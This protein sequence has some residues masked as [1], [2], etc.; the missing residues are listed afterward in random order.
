MTVAG[1]LRYD[2]RVYVLQHVYAWQPPLQNEELWI[3][4]TDQPLPAAAAEDPLLAE[5]L[6]R[7]NRFGGVK[8]IVNPAR[9]R[10]DDIRGVVYAPHTDGY[11]IDQFN[12]GPSWQA[13][14]IADRRVAGRLRTEWMSWALQA[15][16]TA[17]V[18]GSSGTVRTVTGV[19]AQHSPQAEVFIAFE[20][21]LLDSGIEV[22][23][24][25]L[26][27]A[28]LADMRARL[29]R[30]GEAAFREFQ[31]RQRVSTAQ[32][33]ARRQQIERVDSDGD[34][35][36]LNARSGPDSVHTAVLVRIA[37]EWRIAEW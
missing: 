12:F 16:F 23:G 21:A 5:Q 25:Y 1:S 32:G 29:D 27:P 7:E 9:P 11:S 17:P 31:I 2:D 28:K 34:H 6:A 20:Q 3:Y 8:L 37:D 19:A 4:L 24:L 15:D 18:L 22:A 33:E 14:T 35:A 30:L 10:L 36:R 13:L 26:T